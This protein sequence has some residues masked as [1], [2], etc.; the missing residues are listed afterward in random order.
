MYCRNCGKEIKDNTNFCEFCGYE[1]K[2]KN[3]EKTKVSS[4][5]SQ[6]KKPV[7]IGIVVGCIL[8]I[9]CVFCFE[10]ARVTA[11]NEAL[12]SAKY[13][14]E[15]ENYEAA[16]NAYNVAFSKGDN[17]AE[18]YLL[19]AKAYV[20]KGDLY[21][22][23]QTLELG[24][25]NTKCEDLLYVEIW[26]P[27]Q[28]FD[29]LFSFTII[30]DRVVPN[31]RQKF[32]FDNGE[33]I[34]EYY[35]YG[36]ALFANKYYYDTNAKLVG[37][38]L[39]DYS[40][41]EFN[42]GT[43][44]LWCRELNSLSDLFIDTT[45]VYL[46]Y[47]FIY[48]ESDVVEVWT[49]ESE[50]GT[51]ILEKKLFATIYYEKEKCETIIAEDKYTM[52]THD[53]DGSVMTYSASEEEREISFTYDDNGRL[54]T[55]DDSGENHM[56]ISYSSEGDY[57]I[58]K[59]NADFVWRFSSNGLEAASYGDLAEELRIY[60][61]ENRVTEIYEGE[62]LVYQLSYDEEGRLCKGII[63]DFDEQKTIEC[64]YNPYTEE[65][66]LW[67]LEIT[68]FDGDVLTQS[69]VFDEEGRISELGQ[70]NERIEFIYDENGRCISYVYNQ[71]TIYTITY[72]DLGRIVD[73]VRQ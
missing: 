68:D 48:K 40:Q 59:N 73:I 29:L 49:W 26:G 24:Y 23:K 53:E 67:I 42:F 8:I 12:E 17:D 16:I 36:R 38:Q 30:N 50:Y 44:D 65:N 61:E 15:E 57:I 11:K 47:D 41:Y 28:P 43:E 25:A 5:K 70:E 51:G 34:A 6:N 33:I 20:E 56:L 7:I 55:I 64:T 14:M 35:G 52:I 9:G 66:S 10:T 19:Q 18:H 3:T 45:S 13:F 58:S 31:V 69:Y 4:I 22:A 54:V 46:C 39:Y 2:R 21:G 60:T 72:D 32:I 62:K 37:C 71:D 27:S 63:N 1:V